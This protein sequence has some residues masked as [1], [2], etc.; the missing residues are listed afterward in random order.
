MFTIRFLLVGS[1]HAAG[2]YFQYKKSLLTG[3]MT[4]Q[5]GVK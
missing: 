5:K 4:F 1:S 2:I 3:V